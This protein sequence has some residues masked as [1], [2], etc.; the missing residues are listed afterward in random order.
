MAPT[1]HRADLWIRHVGPPPADPAARLLCFP[2]AGGAATAYFPLA[3]ELG[4]AVELLAVQ[5]PGRQDRYGEP[6]IDTVEGL[7]DRIRPQLAAWSDRPLVLFGHSMGAVVAYEVLRWMPSAPGAGPIGL[8]VSGRRAPGVAWPDAV[9]RGGDDALIAELRAL[10]G[11]S[12]VVLDDPEMRE[13]ILPALRAD[14]HAIETYRHRPGPELTV[15][16]TALVG[17]ED[18]KAPVADVKG[19]EQHTSG[20]FELRTF[21]GGHFYLNDRWPA[22]AG[23]I[24]TALTAFGAV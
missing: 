17:A 18:P 15:P 6:A 22:V 1:H 9:H 21:P 3:A 16:V 19:W 7:A 4:D 12:S 11:T 2:H 24:R 23:A 14:Y 10:S 8:I 13:M 20:A 5:Y